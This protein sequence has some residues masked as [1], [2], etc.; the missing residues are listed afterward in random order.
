MLTHRLLQPLVTSCRKFAAKEVKKFYKEAHVT[1]VSGRPG[2]YEVSLDK[3]KL[4]TPMGSLFQV[5][6]ESLALAVATE[7]NAQQGIVKRHNMHFTALCNTAIDNPTFRNKSQIIDAIVHYLD[8]D[9]LCYRMTDPEEL[10]QLQ[11]ALWDPILFWL[12][13]RFKVKMTATS[14]LVSPSVDPET[15]ATLRAHLNSYSDWSLLGFQHCVETLKSLAL[16]LALVDRHL[17]V[18]RAV[19]LSQ[20]E[21][22]FQISKWGNVE[23]Y[24]TIDTVAAQADVAAA[25]LFIH[26]CSESLSTKLKVTSGTPV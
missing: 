9:T 15:E 18:E 5:P 7:W 25:V 11:S 14:G 4:K 22:A 8:T 23:W 26:L 1:Q 17:T 6:G 12:C 2:Y 24:H 19:Y 21:R 13:D 16:T 10:A 3:K 20:L